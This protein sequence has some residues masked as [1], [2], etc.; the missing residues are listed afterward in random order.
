MTFFFLT[1]LLLVQKFALKYLL[2]FIYKFFTFVFKTH[3]PPLI[4]LFLLKLAVILQYK[5][6]QKIAVLNVCITPTVPSNEIVYNTY[7]IFT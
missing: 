1:G 3:R 4:F 5:K 2:L 6:Y 7:S